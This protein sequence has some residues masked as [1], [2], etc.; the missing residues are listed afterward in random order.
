MAN[1]KNIE[2]RRADV[3]LEA[4]KIILSFTTYDSDNDNPPKYIKIDN[5]TTFVC[6]N[7][8][9]EVAY[10]YN[11]D[12]IEAGTEVSNYYPYV[13][14]DEEIDLSLSAFN[15]ETDMLFLFIYSKDDDNPDYLEAVIPMYY[16]QGLYKIG[17]ETIAKEFKNCDCDNND[18]VAS[19]NCVILISGIEYALREGDYQ[20]AIKYWQIIHRS[21]PV[22]NSCN[23]NS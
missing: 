12:P 7:E 15:L 13:V 18:Y 14:N 8:A 20:R 11:L 19:A 21:T 2:I 23:C 17:Y 9:S 5:Q 22:N 3:D 16:E 4:Q 10:T 6:K 1:K